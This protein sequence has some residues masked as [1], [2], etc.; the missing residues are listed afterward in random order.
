MLYTLKKTAES[1]ARTKTPGDQI[2]WM[3]IL[4]PQNIICL[5]FLLL[6]FFISYLIFKAWIRCIL[7]NLSLIQCILYIFEL[8]NYLKVWV[9]T[10][11]EVALLF[12]YF[13]F[14]DKWFS[15]VFFVSQF[16][17]QMCF[18]IKLVPKITQKGC[19]CNFGTFKDY[20]A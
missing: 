14:C 11:Q 13:V 18:F 7:I 1:N 16:D 20:N 6:K 19:V 12:T 5:D 8:F 17:Y 3:T 4:K 9:S 2:Y 15:Y 10:W